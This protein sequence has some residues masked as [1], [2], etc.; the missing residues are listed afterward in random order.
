MLNEFD[1]SQLQ[2][3]RTPENWVEAAVHIPQEKQKPRL[4]R[5]R[6]YSVGAVAVLVIVA[7]TLL[8]LLLQTGQ[9]VKPLPPKPSTPVESAVN[10]TA[11]PSATKASA[12]VETTGVAACAPT[13]RPSGTA[14]PATAAPATAAAEQPQALT[15]PATRPGFPATAST[16]PVTQP[17][18]QPVTQPVTQPATQPVTKP[19]TVPVTVP[20]TQPH[21]PPTEPATDDPG[22][23]ALYFYGRLTF[24]SPINGMFAQND[25]V[26]ADIR[27]AGMS[28]ERI[29]V[30]MKEADSTVVKG[31]LPTYEIG[32]LLF[33]DAPCTV[34]V[35]DGSGHSVSHVIDLTGASDYTIYL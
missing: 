9:T 16:Q 5:F 30:P 12:E 8:T 10:P 11:A 20:L 18:T 15:S 26:Y 33:A 14:A 35:R 29:A 25:T 34:T 27:Q 24:I 32:I 19:A 1:F 7:V 17:I 23:E 2:Q 22:E 28:Y 21:E 6:P 31:V 3:L 4:L 13:T